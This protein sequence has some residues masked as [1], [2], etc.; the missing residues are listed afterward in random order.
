MKTIPELDEEAARRRLRRRM[1]AILRGTFRRLPDLERRICDLRGW[2]AEVAS[3]APLCRALD[4]ALH[5]LD[6]MRRTLA[7]VPA[8]AGLPAAEPA[9]A[10]AAEPLRPASVLAARLQA[11]CEAGGRRLCVLL[12]MARQIGDLTSERIACVLLCVL[13]R[14]LW[15][16]RFH[17]ELVEPHA[18]SRPSGQLQL[19]VPAF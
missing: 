10:A 11:D 2:V 13:E 7:D 3:A 19:R 8:A 9:G 4:G 12:A 1:S 6:S 14:L 17:A 5:E 16:L 18:F 15:L